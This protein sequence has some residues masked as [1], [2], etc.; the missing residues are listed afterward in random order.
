MPVW[1]PKAVEV[2]NATATDE[3]S[4]KPYTEIIPGTDA[5]F[6][7]LPIKGGT[8]V[9]GSP[10]SEEGRK[11]DEGPQHEVEIEPFWMGKCEVTWEEYELWCLKI[12][13]QAR[14]LNKSPADGPGQTRRRDHQ[15]HQALHRHELRHG[16]GGLS[17]DL[18]DPV[19]GQVYCK[20]L[21]AKTGRYYRLPTEAE[22]E[23]ACRAG[24][25]TAYC[26]GDDPEKL[27]DYAWH[28]DNS[29]DKYHKVGKKK[30]NPW[31]LHD[32]HGNVAEWVARPVFGRMAIQLAGK[33][34][35]EPARAGHQSEYNRAVRGGS[36]DDEA[37]LSAKRRTQGLHQG[38]EAAG[39]ADPAEHLVPDRR[40]L[41]GLP[42]G[43]SAADALGGR[44]EALRRGPGTV[45]G[46]G[47]LCQ[48][49]RDLLSGGWPFPPSPWPRRAD[50]HPSPA[51]V[52]PRR[53]MRSCPFPQVTSR[54]A[55]N[56]AGYAG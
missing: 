31:G 52:R 32:M 11:A 35:Q 26:F 49:P 13:E 15:A 14:K 1:L 4:M 17:G 20:W 22:W 41:R 6:D 12:E 10:E 51:G 9:M 37:P 55:R 2:P 25:K 19:C 48:S 47:R 30:P 3:A 33:V 16:Q 54:L 8:F 29:D 28:L 50:K 44:G 53:A 24:T 21:S 36:W 40:Q 7:M 23:Y 39:P 5:K 45:H 34:T 18:H 46:N 43:P 27:D 56:R 42:R 38:L